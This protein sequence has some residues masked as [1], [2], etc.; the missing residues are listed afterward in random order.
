HTYW[1]DLPAD[2][3]PELYLYGLSL[4]S[5]GVESVLNSIEI[6]NSPIDGALMSGPPFVNPLHS[7][8]MDERD[9]QSPPF[10]PVVGD[11][12]TVRFRNLDTG[13]DTPDGPWGPTRIAYLQHNSDAITFFSPNLAFASPDWLQDGSRAPDVSEKMVWRPVITMCQVA[14]DPVAAGDVPRG[15][16]Q[17]YSAR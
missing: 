11:G 8:L 13:F 1:S 3:R 10:Q 2:Q 12:A 9:P 16:G 4:G 14:A 5:Y 17:H 6:V 15:H 7:R